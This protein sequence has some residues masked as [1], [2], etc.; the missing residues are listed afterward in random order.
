MFTL[1][2]DSDSA[3]LEA[4]SFSLF[5]WDPSAASDLALN[6]AEAND[7]NFAVPPPAEESTQS[8]FSWDDSPR[9][10]L[11]Q[12]AQ[13]SASEAEE[14]M[15]SQFSWDDPPRQPPAQKAQLSAIQEVGYFKLL[16]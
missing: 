6:F 14:S 5:S 7:G 9:Q 15:Q 8:H 3:A 1:A 10:P 4:A 11:A 16:L 12:Q 13:L 2:P